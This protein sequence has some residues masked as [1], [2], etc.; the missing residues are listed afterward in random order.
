MKKFILSG[1]LLIS[2][3]LT[4]AASAENDSGLGKSI[5]FGNDRVDIPKQDPMDFSDTQQ[6]ARCRE[7]SMKMEEKRYRPQQRL[8]YKEAYSVECLNIGP[9]QKTMD[10]GIGTDDKWLQLY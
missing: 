10:F 3:G 5:M 9:M 2:L 4:S 1:V 7:L 8:M 6:D